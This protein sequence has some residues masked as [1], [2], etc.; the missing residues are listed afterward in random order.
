M[1]AL[2]EPDVLPEPELGALSE[3]LA[4]TRLVTLTG[5]GGIGKSRLAA[6]LAESTRCT[7]APVH[8][9][10]FSGCPDVAL[11]PYTVAAALH[12]APAP[13]TDPV[14]AVLDLLAGSRGLLVLDTCEHVLTGCA[15]LVG[16]L[17]DSCPGLRILTTS[18]RPLGVPDEDLVEVPPLPRDRTAGLLQEHAASYGVELPGCWAGRLAGQLDGDPLSTLLAARSLRQLTARQLHAALGAPGGR[19]AV[20]TDGPGDPAR[21]RTLLQAVEWSHELCSRAE[22]LL[23]AQLS[24]F[25]GEFTAEQVRTVFPDGSSLA[26]LVSSSVV[27][28]RGDGTYRLPLAHREYGKLRLAGLGDGLG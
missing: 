22:R 1:A 28:A 15:Y 7:G 4:A 18:R 26:S 25:T 9:V 19:F 11:V 5:P 16:R 13:G 23:W 14:R 8:R 27:H 10:D 2:P 24:A 3:R 6:R 17:H 20:L 21:H 12:T